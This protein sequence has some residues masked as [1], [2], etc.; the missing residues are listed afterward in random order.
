[1]KKIALPLINNHISQRFEHCSEF[2]IF[3][4]KKNNSLKKNLLRTH[5]QPDIFPHWLAEK[6]VTDIITKGIDIHTVNEFNKF[7]ISVFAGV[8]P[9][10]PEQ[11]VEELLNG[12]LETNV[13]A[14]KS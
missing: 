4:I 9:S 2:V 1:M 6:G 5:L 12:S 10:D 7:K 14:D 3:T 13:I 11:L 8:E